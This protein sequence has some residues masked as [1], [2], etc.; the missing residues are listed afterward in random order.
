MEKRKDSVGRSLPLWLLVG[1]CAFAGVQAA[2]QDVEVVDEVVEG[3]IVESTVADELGVDPETVNGTEPTPEVPGPAE[4]PAEEAQPMEPE[5]IEPEYQEPVEEPVTPQVEPTFPRRPTQLPGRSVPRPTTAR[6]G[7]SQPSRQGSPT[8]STPTPPGEVLDLTQTKRPAPGASQPESLYFDFEN[9]QLMQVIKTVASIIGKNF[10][11]DPQLAASEV[12]IISHAPIPADM[13]YEVLESILT[14]RGFQMIPHLDGNLILIRPLLQDPEKMPLYVG[15]E[16]S[17]GVPPGYDTFST[18]IVPVQYADAAEVAPLLKTLGSANARVDAYGNTNTLILTDTA[19]GLRNML[20]FLEVIDVEG[21]STKMQIFTL[22]Y[23]SAETLSTQIEEVLLGGAEGGARVAAPGQ[24]QQPVRPITTRATVRAPIPGAQQ[25]T[26]VGAREEILRIVPDLRLNALIVIATEGMME[27]VRDLIE[28]LDTPTPIE[29]N[30]MHI[31]E[32]LNA[33][34]EQVEQ[35][36]NALIST[37]PRQ[38][39][40]G[41]PVAQTAEVQPFEKKVLVTRY[42]QTN[43][44][45]IIAAP[46]D[47]KRIAEVIALLDV[48]QRQVHVEAVIMEVTIGDRY[49]LAVEMV[50][51]DDEH[52]FGLNNVVDL[53]NILATGPLSA[54]TGD[55]V[56]TAGYIDGTTE[57]P[58]IGEDGAITTQTIPN[59]PLLITALEA[60]TDLDVLSQPALVTVDN[61][62][63]SIV[64]GQEVPFITGSSSSLDQAAVGRSVFNRIDREDVGIKMTVTPQISEGDF[65]FLD[66]DVEVSQPIESTVGADPNLVGPTLQKSQV[67]NKVVVKDGATGIIGGLVSESTSRTRR[68]PPLF[69]D[70]P[71]VGVLFRRTS[72]DRNKRNL[73]V[74]VTPNIVKQGTDL[75]RMT[76]YKVNEFQRVNADVLFEKGLIKKI[77]QRHY[78]RTDY[79]PSAGKL[80][81][82]DG[83]SF[84][85]GRIGAPGSR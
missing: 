19:Q 53:A 65:V 47:Y 62:E 50:G 66:L 72:D 16:T 82:F 20:M 46:E 48:P 81:S 30:N 42:E 41:Q 17:E 63:A 75:T 49:Q 22:Q 24:Q 6:P 28:K 37:T 56:L 44:L 38:G 35:A 34:A 57:I 83:T 40:E 79:R 12:T 36:L 74:L 13:A 3:Q 54:S 73:V 78:M 23:T 18:H 21:Q 45:L 33:R 4:L 84:N 7:L 43:A 52:F 58:V 85:R 70:L 55:N 67:K 77:K 5:P 8:L 14:A 68:Q 26:I 61:E 59:I 71:L 60:L 51:L 80:E 9:V 32:L 64:I 31:Y 76:E 11:I 69:G 27:R 39:A 10:D 25:S 1:V 2:A 15:T 29:Q